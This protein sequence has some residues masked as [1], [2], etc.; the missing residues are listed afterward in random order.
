MFLVWWFFVFKQKTAY[1]MRISDWSSDVCSSDLFVRLELPVACPIGKIP[2]FGSYRRK[3][4]AVC[5]THDRREQSAFDRNRNADI[6]AGEAEYPVLRPRRI[7][8]RKGHESLG[9]C[10]NHKIVDGDLDRSAIIHPLPEFQH[11]LDI[12]VR[13]QIEMRNRLFRFNEPPGDRATHPVKLDFREGRVRIKCLDLIKLGAG[14]ERRRYEIGRA[15][16]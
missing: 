8:C 14:R 12:N 5:A 15:H 3:A 4:L 9:I 13:R 7:S 2:D 10:L 1:E 16:V 11:P 6:R